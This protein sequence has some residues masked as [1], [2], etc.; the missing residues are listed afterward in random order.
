L[1]PR[2]LVVA[3]LLRVPVVHLGKPQARV[4]ECAFPVLHVPEETA[5]RH[6]AERSTSSLSRKEEEKNEEETEKEE[7]EE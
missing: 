1:L 7:E 3:V 4:R 5:K 6:G 2:I